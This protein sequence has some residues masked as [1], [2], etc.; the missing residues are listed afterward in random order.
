MRDFLIENQGKS[1]AELVKM[2]GCSVRTI[3]EHQA[4]LR[5][6]GVLPEATGGGVK[7][8]VLT[9][10][11]QF[12]IDMEK[13]R[14]KHQEK[15]TDRK[16]Q[17]AMAQINKLRDEIDKLVEMKGTVAS[18][19]ILPK[20]GQKNES[21]AF[22]ILSDTHIEENVKP[23]SVDGANEY[24]LKIAKFRM[25][26]FFRNTVKLVT[27]EQ[28]DANID[29]L[30][31]ALLGDLISS[32]I[33]DELLE[34]C[35]VPPVEAAI[36]AQ[37]FITSGIDYILKN[38]KLKLVVPCCVGNHS[39]ITNQ[40]HV[41][42]E[43]GNSLEWMIYCNLASHY[44]EN[45]RVQFVLSK[46]YFTWVNVFGYDIRFHHGHAMK[47][48]GGIGSITIPV[49]KAIARYDMSKKAYLDVFG[50]FHNPMDGGKFISNGCMIGDTP[51]GKRLGFTGKPQQQ[52]FLIDKHYGK[53]GVFPI[54]LE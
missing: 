15:G 23:E 11:Q 31:L 8:P 47:Y 48:G 26:A 4:K 50:H 13:L 53:T 37:N 9:D 44:K 27:K 17:V 36:L 21:V 34:S 14:I 10:E 30:V 39:R 54:F 32:N 7:K 40:V 5:A 29:T 38:T 51:Y 19:E 3:N 6:E 16:Y 49:L 24:N 33:H 25:E 1:R 20:K 2:R 42:T 18:Y 35:E 22:A 28:Q 45:K 12:Q 52:F 46:S 41:S 43:Q